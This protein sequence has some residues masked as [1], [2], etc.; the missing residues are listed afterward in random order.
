M[1]KNYPGKDDATAEMVATTA[2]SGYALFGTLEPGGYRD[3]DV[4]GQVGSF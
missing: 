2:D 4:E 1:E 3:D